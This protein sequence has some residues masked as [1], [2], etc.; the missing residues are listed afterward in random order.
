LALLRRLSSFSLSV[1]SVF[2]SLASFLLDWVEK[3]GCQNLFQKAS[4]MEILVSLFFS[5]KH[6]TTA[7][8]LSTFL[9]VA[10]KNESVMDWALLCFSW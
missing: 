1:A 10:M 2:G 8:D 5:K 4:R 3:E 9:L 7:K 6:L